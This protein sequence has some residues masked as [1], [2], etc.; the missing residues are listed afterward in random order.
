MALS[1]VGYD[2]ADTT[3]AMLAFKRHFRQD[4]SAQFNEADKSVLSQLIQR[5]LSGK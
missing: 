1:I 4:S 5:K 2:V 3:A